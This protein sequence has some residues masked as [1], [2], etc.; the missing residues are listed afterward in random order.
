MR[1]TGVWESGEWAVWKGYRESLG[2]HSIVCRWLWK[3]EEIDQSQKCQGPEKDTRRAS[4]IGLTE[5]LSKLLSLTSRPRH[6][7]TR[8]RPDHQQEASPRLWAPSCV[9]CKRSC[10]LGLECVALEKNGSCLRHYLPSL[11]GRRGDHHLLGKAHAFAIQFLCIWLQE[12]NVPEGVWAP[13]VPSGSAL[14]HSQRMR[15]SPS[16]YFPRKAT[17][18]LRFRPYN[19]QAPLQAPAMHFLT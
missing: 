11:L 5:K 19:I 4:D 17:P 3:E 13:Y 10:L 12:T 6:D 8:L 1:T 18:D 2:K 16:S 14:K 9:R 7:H 15:T